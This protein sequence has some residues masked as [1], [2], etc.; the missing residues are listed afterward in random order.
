MTPID[1]YIQNSEHCEHAPLKDRKSFTDVKDLKMVDGVSFEVPISE[2]NKM[3]WR[4]VKVEVMSHRRGSRDKDDG[5]TR[6]TLGCG[7]SLEHM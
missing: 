2:E 5:K 4:N 3:W 7:F 6:K 1:A